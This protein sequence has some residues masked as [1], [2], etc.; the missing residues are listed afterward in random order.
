M[1]AT[2]GPQ[3]AGGDGFH[4]GSLNPGTGG[5][6]DS[7]DPSQGSAWSQAEYARETLE[8]VSGPKKSILQRAWIAVR[9]SLWGS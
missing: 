5:N 4:T 6:R 1:T 8:D 7:Y 3:G 2:G 9:R